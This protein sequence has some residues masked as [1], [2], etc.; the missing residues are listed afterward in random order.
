MLKKLELDV[1]V[2]SIDNEIDM[3]FGLETLKGASD[4]VS[5]IAEAILEN[6]I[7]GRRT[8][9]SNGV[10][11]KL[12]QSF[13]GSFGQRF[14]LEITKPELKSKLRK[15]GDDV[16]LEV[17]SYFVMEALYLDSGNL[18][19]EAA[20]VLDDMG[21]ISKGLLKRL[22]KPLIDMHQ[23]AK[24]F[25]QNVSLRHKKYGAGH[26]QLF[27]LTNETCKN[28]TETVIDPKQ[29]T[30]EAVIIRYH[31]KTGNGRLHIKGKEEFYSFGFGTE[32]IAVKKELRTQISS[33]LHFNTIKNVD[34]SD[35][36]KLL[37]KCIKLPTGNIV[38]YLILGIEV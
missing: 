19:K 12:K 1:V 33:N 11:T 22:N 32:M 25:S 21:D 28:L 36:I 24:Y 31:S 10:R 8:H 29:F 23:L 5:L 37:V 9:K 34:E 17:L 6:N 30:I 14:A 3:Q 20:N 2:E 38:K 13:K 26:R 35:Y 7:G 27:Q 16:F 4:V 18:S 15:M